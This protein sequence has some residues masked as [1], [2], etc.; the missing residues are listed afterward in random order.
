MIVELISVGTEILMG[1]IVNTNSAYLAEQCAGLGFSLYYMT[2]V[3]DNEERLL[4][5]I[6]MAKERADIVIL[7]GGLGPTMDDM[8]KEMVAKACGLELVEDEGCK[9][10]IKEYFEKRKLY[11]EITENNWKQA[12]IPKGAI[13]LDNP[14][15]TANGII[16]QAER[17]HLILLPGPPNELKPLFEQEVIPYL[18]TLQDASFYT[19]MIKISGIGESYVEDKLS[20]LIQGQ[21]N[22]TIAPYAKEGE[23][24]I[25]VTAKGA[26]EQEAKQL[27][28][29]T[30]DEIRNRIGDAIFTEE[31]AVTLE[32][33]VIA[34]LE[35]HELT[36]C[37]VESCTGGLFSGRLV[38]VA[39]ASSVLKQGFITYSNE[40]KQKLVNVKAETLQQYGAVS[41]QTAKEM[42]VGGS[43]VS[44][45]DVAISITGIAGPDGGSKEKPVGLV[46]IGCYMNG[47]VWTK[48][49]HFTGNRSKIRESSVAN[50]LTLL[51]YHIL[52]QYEGGFRADK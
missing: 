47:H 39:G 11:H 41:H 16:V 33:Q 48:E 52:E 23:V 7:S 37:T 25:R 1:N 36:L 15:G 17:C 8:T 29:P 4:Q 35:Q 50:A 46:Y 6:K 30:V 22:P 45:C 24:H 26:N 5:T 51:R 32:Q 9:E 34:L 31:E 19:A 27:V 10:H 28:S 13:V 49:F 20:D 21:T 38:N 3:G 42:A 2:T 43:Q 14:N 44:N 40:S 18:K 12:Q